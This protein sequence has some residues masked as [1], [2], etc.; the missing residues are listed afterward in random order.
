MSNNN[1]VRNVQ[2]RT[3]ASET[4][5]P[6][7]FKWEGLSVLIVI[8]IIARN[9]ANTK[10]YVRSVLYRIA[11]GGSAGQQDDAQNNGFSFAAGGDV[12]DSSVDGQL[13]LN[14]ETDAAFGE[15]SDWF[16]QYEYIEFPDPL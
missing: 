15:S 2:T 11:E 13:T 9:N 10:Q 5:T 16:F 4:P 6:I 3:I 14:I 7:V 8:K 12:F 1:L